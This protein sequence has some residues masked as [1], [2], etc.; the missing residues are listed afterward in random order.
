MCTLKPSMDSTALKGVFLAQYTI[1][2][3]SIYILYQTWRRYGP[4]SKRTQRP[5]PYIDSICAF[6][7]AVITILDNK[8]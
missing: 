3:W 5:R 6:S 7:D 8:Q 2:I 4:V 1:W